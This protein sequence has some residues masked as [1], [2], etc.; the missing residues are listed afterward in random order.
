MG[1]LDI[2]IWNSEEGHEHIIWE[3]LAYVGGIQ[4]CETDDPFHANV[5]AFCHY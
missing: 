5:T 1:K 2:Q 3:L 4:S